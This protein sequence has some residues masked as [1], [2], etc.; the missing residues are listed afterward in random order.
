MAKSPKQKF[1]YLYLGGVTGTHDSV[2]ER[3]SFG[4]ATTSYAIVFKDYAIIVDQ[5]SGVINIIK[6]LRKMGIKK[7]HI[8]FTH[9]HADHQCGLQSNGLLLAPGL[10]QGLYG[11]KLEKNVIQIFDRAFDSVN[12]PISPNQTGAKHSFGVFPPGASIEIGTHGEGVTGKIQTFALTHP[13][14]AVAFRVPTEHGDIVIATDH[15][16]HDRAGHAAYADFVSGAAM[17][18]T[19]IQYRQH[20]FDGTLGIADMPAM[21]RVGWGHSSPEMIR[22]ALRHCSVMPR[23]IVG[24]HHD[25]LRDVRDLKRFEREASVVFGSLNTKF[26]FARQDQIIEMA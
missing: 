4:G 21:S 3:G 9:Y 13:G 26:I 22:D 5:G 20:E 14:G 18:V 25:P 12:W 7:F 19:D 11:P 10:C 6:H 16:A 15:E 17:L 23:I 24:V 2:E 8:I 1:P